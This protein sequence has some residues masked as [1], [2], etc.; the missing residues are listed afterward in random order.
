[1][2][3]QNPSARRAGFALAEV[4]PGLLFDRPYL[5]TSHSPSYDVN[6]EGRFL[7]IENCS[8]PE[9]EAT[10]IHVVLNWFEELK[11]LVPTV[12][13]TRSACPQTEAVGDK[14]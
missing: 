12:S 4:L 14:E 3:D 10:E 11:Q 2:W 6:R 13:Q 5:G 7:M 9:Q 8:H 1:M